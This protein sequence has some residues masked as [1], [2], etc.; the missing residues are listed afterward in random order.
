M[1][2]VKIIIF[3]LGLLG[4]AFFAGSETAFIY[5]SAGDASP[6][7]KKLKKNMHMLLATT[8]F[9]VNISMVLA[10]TV[11]ADIFIE[12]F[13]EHI[14]G[15]ISIFSV[16]I[17]VLMFGEIMP[18]SLALRNSGGFSALSAVPLRIVS[19]VFYPIIFMFNKISHPIAK[20]LG[21]YIPK[22][23]SFTH[24]DILHFAKAEATGLS[25]EKRDVLVNILEFE[26]IK[27]HE[28]MKPASSFPQLRKSD[29]AEKAR[30][31]MDKLHRNIALVSE[32]GLQYEGYVLRRGGLSMLRPDD[33]IAPIVLKEPVLPI[34]QTAGSAI[35]HLSRSMSESALVSDESGKIEGLIT[36]NTLY[37]L[38]GE[39]PSNEMKLQENIQD[40]FEIKSEMLIGELEQ[41]IQREISTSRHYQSV[42]GML[43]E[44]FGHMPY[45]GESLIKNGWRF[46]V[47]TSTRRKI[48]KVLVKKLDKPIK[49][50]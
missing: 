18:K 16:S 6:F 35:S 25:D 33:T 2:S 13:G 39:A 42:G 44:N 30:E 37:N 41:K 27:L 9:G 36:L 43:I 48:G 20:F 8:L 40:E 12:I 32:D 24:N 17:M 31:K 11:A 3:F 23:Q 38:L 7:V 14:G 26:S 4:Q 46:I 10:S 1:F 15:I 49:Q 34:T 19:I 22:K 5:V 28:I 47:M 50:L 21:L 29:T 45:P